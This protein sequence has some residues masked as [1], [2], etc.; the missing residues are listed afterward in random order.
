M[1]TVQLLLMMFAACAGAQLPDEWGE[2]VD[3]GFGDLD[4][5]AGNLRHVEPGLRTIGEQTSLYRVY[6]DAPF[7]EPTYQRVGQGFRV[8]YARPD[9]LVGSV[10]DQVE[11]NIAPLED[12]RFVELIP[13]GA[14][15]D[16]SPRPLV[17]TRRAASSVQGN[18]IDGRIDGR[19]DARVDGRVWQDHRAMVRRPLVAAPSWSRP[20]RGRPGSTPGS[21]LQPGWRR[22]GA[23]EGAGPDVARTP[24][25][26]RTRRKMAPS[27]AHHPP[28]DDAKSGKASVGPSDTTSQTA[29][30]RDRS[31]SAERSPGARD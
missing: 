17:A 1:R 13:P 2:P 8:R 10:N 27:R 15:F 21:L 3:Q 24:Q 9:Y 5:L 11:L 30:K 18:Y 7:D 29:I 31:D 19:V 6:P 4:P 25:R 23:S 28:A 20:R 14:I 26:P 22:V 16:L 12:G